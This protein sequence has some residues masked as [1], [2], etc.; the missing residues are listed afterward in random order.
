MK[1]LQRFLP[2]KSTRVNATAYNLEETIMVEGV[3]PVVPFRQLNETGVRKKV[4]EEMQARE[5]TKGWSFKDYNSMIADKGTA[6]V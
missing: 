5:L 4:W 1:E 2:R 3:H 6:K